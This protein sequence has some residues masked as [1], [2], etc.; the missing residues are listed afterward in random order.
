MTTNP[1]SAQK[2]RRNGSPSTSKSI[3]PLRATIPVS[4]MTQPIIHD[5][6]EDEN[7]QNNWSKTQTS[8]NA[9]TSSSSNLPIGVAKPS[10]WRL[11]QMSPTPKGFHFPFFSLYLPSFLV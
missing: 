4:L 1:P 9:T 5:M 6:P 8:S 10:S 7:S 2:L 11:R 3:G